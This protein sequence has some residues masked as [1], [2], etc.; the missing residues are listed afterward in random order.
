MTTMDDL[1]G[2]EMK[3][4][5]KGNFDFENLLVYQLA[6]KVL[7]LLSK[8]A[9]KPPRK[10]ASV[11]DHLDRALDS[12]LLNIAEGTGKDRGSRDRARF[13]KI[14]LGSAKEAAAALDILVLRS[15]IR[16]EK[17]EEAR[18][19]LRRIVGMLHNMSR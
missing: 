16:P 4:E 13:Y 15:F 11:A 10:A 12:I 6:R 5:S 19:L 9:A 7:A 8:W 17:A 3:T 14:A 18:I 1:K 2:I